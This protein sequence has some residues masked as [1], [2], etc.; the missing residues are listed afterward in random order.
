MITHDVSIL[1]QGGASAGAV[2]GHFYFH[3]GGGLHAHRNN[4]RGKEFAHRNKQK[5]A[6]PHESASIPEE[7]KSNSELRGDKSPRNTSVPK[8][9]STERK[10]RTAEGAPFPAI[11]V[12]FRAYRKNGQISQN[13]L[14]PG[15]K[16]VD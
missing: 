13:R 4:T 8:G 7:K 12:N 14:R 9:S 15:K 11:K 6:R 2:A 3:K 1:V 5:K 10:G 16:K